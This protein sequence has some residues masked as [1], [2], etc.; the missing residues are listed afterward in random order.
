MSFQG[1]KDWASDVQNTIMGWM[2]LLPENSKII[3]LGLDNAGID[4]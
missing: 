1:I 4:F 3:F 2:G